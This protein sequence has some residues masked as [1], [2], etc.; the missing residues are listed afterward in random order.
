MKVVI[1]PPFDKGPSPLIEIVDPNGHVHVASMLPPSSPSLYGSFP[2]ASIT[3]FTI[4]P[5]SCAL[6]LYDA[7]LI[8][9]TPNPIPHTTIDGSV[10]AISSEITDWWPMFHHDLRHTGYSTS[11][12]PKTN[13]TAWTFTT[14]E[15]HDWPD[16][17]SLSL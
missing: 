1:Q 8:D 5:G 2:L 3:F 10:N 6:H 16:E 11:K 12:V 15:P 9:P 13:N 4:L 17:S 14:G 7:T